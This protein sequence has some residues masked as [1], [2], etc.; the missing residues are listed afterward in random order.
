MLPLIILTFIVH[1]SVLISYIYMK[2]KTLKKIKKKK[3]I[4]TV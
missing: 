4:Y 2:T 3:Y 1:P